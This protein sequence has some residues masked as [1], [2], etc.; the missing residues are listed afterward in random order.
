MSTICHI[1]EC[2]PQHELDF[3]SRAVA[4]VLSDCLAQP[5]LLNKVVPCLLV[6]ARLNAM[7][8]A[9]PLAAV[10][11][12]HGR[13]PDGRRWSRRRVSRSRRSRRPSSPRAGARGAQRRRPSQSALNWTVGRVRWRVSAEACR[14]TISR[15][16]ARLNARQSRRRR[17]T[18]ASRPGRFIPACPR[19]GYAS[20]CSRP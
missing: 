12:P 2:A 5:R 15:G 6:I 3:C 16:A 7:F 17:Q 1:V 8:S 14:S 4:I 13:P 10:P 19:F 9:G 11:Y 20:C 18:V